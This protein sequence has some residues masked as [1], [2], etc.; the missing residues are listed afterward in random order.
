MG[1]C[2]CFSYVR[3]NASIAAVSLIEQAWDPGSDVE[4]EEESVE[5]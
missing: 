3:I 4:F 1:D 5:G 2:N